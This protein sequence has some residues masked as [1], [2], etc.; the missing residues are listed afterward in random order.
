ME[1]VRERSCCETG[2]P[3][4]SFLSAIYELMPKRAT[5][6]CTTLASQLFFPDWSI[7]MYTSTILDEATGKDLRRQR[8][9]RRPAVTRRW[10][11]CLST[12]CR[13]PLLSPHLLPSAKQRTNDAG[14]IG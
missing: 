13:Q 14:W 6:R 5:S 12:V 3:I 7:L 1:F 2:K 9:R 8:E 11:T 4:A 10:S